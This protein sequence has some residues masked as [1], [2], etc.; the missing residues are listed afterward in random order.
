MA[1]DN[2]EARYIII[3]SKK[4]CQQNWNQIEYTHHRCRYTSLQR[5]YNHHY[6]PEIKMLCLLAEIRQPEGVSCLHHQNE[7]RETN[8]LHRLG[9]DVVRGMIIFIIQAVFANTDNDMSDMAELSKET[10]QLAIMSQLFIKEIQSIKNAKTETDNVLNQILVKNI[11]TVPL[12]ML[13]S[14][15]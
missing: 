4:L 9:E 11:K 14:N 3:L 8:S 15:L 6:Q 12:D 13:S 5:K 2:I 10:D 7:T 1:L